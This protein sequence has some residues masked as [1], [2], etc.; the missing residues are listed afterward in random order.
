V[1]DNP[2]NVFKKFEALTR[3]SRGLRRLGSAAIDF[4]YVAKGIFDGFWEVSLNPWDICGG[5][6]ILEEAGGIV[7][8]FDGN[9]IEIT[10]KRILATNRLVHKAMVEILQKN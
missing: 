8:D 4:C 9:E 5:K 7:T 3:A 1:A 10:S 2:D 6:L